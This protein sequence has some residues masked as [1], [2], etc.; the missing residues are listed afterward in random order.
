MLLAVARRAARG[1]AG[2]ASVAMD[3]AAQIRERVR[4]LV[5]LSRP[6][7]ALE[8]ARRARA[9][10]DASPELDE[11]EG[12]A[13]I[14]LGDFPAAEAALVRGLRTS[15][16][17][18][19]LHYLRSFAAR[20]AERPGDARKSLMEALRLAPEEPV[21]LRAYAELLSDQKEHAAALSAAHAAVHHGPDRSANHVT[22]GFVASAAGDKVLARGSYERALELDPEDSAAW[23][24]LGCLDLELGRELEARERFREA[25]RIAPEGPRA[26]RNLAQTLK[27]RTL[28]GFVT[29]EDWVRGLA[30]ELGAADELRLLSALAFEAEEGRTV[31]RAAMRRPGKGRR[32]AALAGVSAWTIW[33]L[34]RMR[35]LPA[36]V[37]AGVGIAASAGAARAIAAERARVRATLREGRIAFAAIRRDWLDGKLERETRDAAARRLLERATLALCRREIP[38]ETQHAKETLP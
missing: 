34:L 24:N 3:N 32:F 28:E 31:L 20:S 16:D 9:R 30:E 23:N 11:L 4:L 22:L 33:G 14:R 8:L 25:L 26:Q 38:A 6:K 36:L 13:L 2:G 27:G 15:P 19:H 37:G 10:G 21:Y 5:E 29:F 17:R 35:G 1:H 12:L 18:P 7:E